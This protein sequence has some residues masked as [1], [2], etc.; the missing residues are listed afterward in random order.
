V[1]KNT[2]PGLDFQLL[3]GSSRLPVLGIW[4]PFLASEGTHCMH[5]VHRHAYGQ[6][7]NENKNKSFFFFL[8]FKDLIMW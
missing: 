3:H 6:T 8:S 1:A 7:T 5:V 4:G 2:E